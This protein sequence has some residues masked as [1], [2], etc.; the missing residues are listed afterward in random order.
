MLFN[1]RKYIM[2]DTYLRLGGTSAS[3][4]LIGTD[5]GSDVI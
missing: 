5:A 4:T 1:M 2:A 3:E